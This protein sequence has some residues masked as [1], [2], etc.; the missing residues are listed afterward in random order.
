MKTSVAP[1][2]HLRRV[3]VIL[4]WSGLMAIALATLLPQPTIGPAESVLCVVCGPLGGV[5]GLLNV[6]LFVPLGA[7]LALSG[8]LWKRSLMSMFAL[9][10]LIEIAQFF[11]IPGRY[12]ALGDVL[13]NGVGG[14]LGYA[15]ACYGVTLMRPSPRL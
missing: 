13:A 1:T 7:G 8:H 15:A 11:I 12:A 2:P 4:S 3:G 9:S 10:A 14:A 6:F 5:S